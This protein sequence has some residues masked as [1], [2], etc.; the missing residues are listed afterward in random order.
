[1]YTLYM[2]NLKWFKQV[3]PLRTWKLP[4]CMYTY[5]LDMVNVKWFKQVEQPLQT[6]VKTTIL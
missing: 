2:I 6:S 1:M 4:H 3:E 5:S